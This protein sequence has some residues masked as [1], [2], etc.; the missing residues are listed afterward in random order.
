MRKEKRR[1][2]FGAWKEKIR[3]F[4]R[5]A[6]TV[7]LIAFMILP[8]RAA[9]ADDRKEGVTEGKKIFIHPNG[10]AFWGWDETLCSAL[11]DDS[12]DLYDFISE[13]TAP[14]RIQT[15]AIADN[16]LYMDT[17][18]GLYRMNLEEYSQGSSVAQQLFDS[19]LIKGFQLYDDYAYFLSGSTLYR[20]P[21]AGG[22]KEEL[23]TGAEDMELTNQGIYYTDEDGGLFLLEFDGSERSFVTDTPRESTF[24]FGSQAIYY[25]SEEEDSLYQYSLADETVRKVGL[26]Q[27]FDPTD[28]VWVADN[29]L[30]YSSGLDVYKHELSTGNEWEMDYFYGLMGKEDGLFLDDILYY[31]IG[32]MVYWDNAV[33]GECKKISMEDAISG[34]QTVTSF[35]GDGTASG[36]NSGDSG[37]ADS[38]AA[39][40]E[41]SAEADSGSGYDIAE[42]ISIGTSEGN[43]FV[44]STYFTLYLPGDAD[45][46]FEVVDQ[47]AV[48]FYHVPSREAGCGGTLVTI[49]AYDWGDN[50]YGDFPS[51]KIAGVSDAKKYVAIFPTDL[52]CD[53]ENDQQMAEYQR[54][55]EYVKRIDSEGANNPFSVNVF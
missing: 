14:F 36:S 37:S 1:Q 19:M 33:T 53:P 41:G 52:Q 2:C 42:N 17:S 30:L 13:G 16:Y 20:V 55:L 12:G 38:G 35:G 21:V 25:W 8:V 26:Q 7:F 10:V 40:A 31:A 48:L 9:A 50:E 24:T 18:K 5:L 22:D 49:K 43:A 46:D 11:Q 6:L 54:L 47:T 29:Y 23:A 39:A 34:D 32:D 45:W 44:S 3:K 27:E 51:W 4:E 28:C 15:V